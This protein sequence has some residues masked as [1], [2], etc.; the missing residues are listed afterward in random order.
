M[1]GH[2]RAGGDVSTRDAR[3]TRSPP[4]LLQPIRSSTRLPAPRAPASGALCWDRGLPGTPLQE[5]GWGRGQ[6]WVVNTTE[7]F[8]RYQLVNLVVKTKYSRD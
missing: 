6:G 1:V 7:Q 5:Q 2:T 3:L 4:S 8:R